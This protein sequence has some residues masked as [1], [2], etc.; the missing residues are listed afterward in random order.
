MK[1]FL[2]LIL[3]ATL[4]T[5]PAFSQETREIKCD[6]VPVFFAYALN[7][8]DAELW[9]EFVF[10]YIGAYRVPWG[11]YY[12]KSWYFLWPDCQP[13]PLEEFRQ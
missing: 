5:T 8:P 7:G 1:L 2:S 12:P 3:F 10:K 11:V 9:A 4:L 13:D 6:R